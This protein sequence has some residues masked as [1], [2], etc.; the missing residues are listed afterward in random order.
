[1]FTPETNQIRREINRL[2]CEQDMTEQQAVQI[3][4]KN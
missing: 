3:V 4:M 2:V 1:M